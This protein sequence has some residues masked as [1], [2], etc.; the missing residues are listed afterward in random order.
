MFA[1]LLLKNASISLFIDF[2]LLK[3]SYNYACDISLTINF[4]ID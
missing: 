3:L 4:E 1:F 2:L